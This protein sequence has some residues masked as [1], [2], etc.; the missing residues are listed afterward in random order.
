MGKKSGRQQG[1]QHQLRSN[2][3]DQHTPISKS[4]QNEKLHRNLEKRTYD[5][6]L[7]K[8]VII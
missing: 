3:I 2:I 1:K 6:S 4:F 8:R 5:E 7:Q